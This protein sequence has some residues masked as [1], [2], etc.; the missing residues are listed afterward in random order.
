MG[1]ERAG[2][3]GADAVA[4]LRVA[5]QIDEALRVTAAPAR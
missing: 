3:G 1:G 5:E 2:A 4:A